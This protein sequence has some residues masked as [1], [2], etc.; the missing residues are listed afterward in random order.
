MENKLLQF[1]GMAD[2]KYLINQANN[3][4]FQPIDQRILKFSQIL[5][6]FVMSILG[7]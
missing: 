3:N 2:K 7:E 6:S 1:A 4:S 5:N